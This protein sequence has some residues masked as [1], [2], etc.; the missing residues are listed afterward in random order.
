MQINIP[1]NELTAPLPVGEVHVIEIHLPVLHLID[2]IFR[3]AKVAHLIQDLRDTL[4]GG[5]G[6]RDHDEDHRDHHEG[7]EDIH[8]VGKQGHELTGRQIACDDH[9]GAEPGND[10]D[11]H[12]DGSLHDRHVDD[13]IVLRFH[14][15]IVN[16]GCCSRE[17]IS[18][19]LLAD[20]GL[21]DADACDIFLNGFIQGV[22]LFEDHAEIPGR[23]YH[24]KSE[25][26]CQRNDRDEIDTRDPRVD[27]KCHDHGDDHR[28][29]CADEHAQKHLVRVLQIGDV[30]RQSGDESGRRELIDVGK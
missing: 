12:I 30:R 20:V 13:D 29:R 11:D 15:Q 7:H 5:G 26:N 4:R 14:E 6:H 8:T 16:V 18:L 10:Q 2:R 3:I 21:D 23:A 19:V 28:E 9:V 27:D 24:D 1:E 17:L 22:I 25:E